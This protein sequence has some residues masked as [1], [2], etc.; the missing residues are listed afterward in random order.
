MLLILGI[1]LKCFKL[2]LQEIPSTC[3]GTFSYTIKTYEEHMTGKNDTVALCGNSTC[4]VDVNQDAHRIK[5]TVFRNE[6]LL[7]EESV[8]VPATGESEF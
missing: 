3:Q 1:Y 6:I 8:Y 2:S 7:V 5:L 4:E